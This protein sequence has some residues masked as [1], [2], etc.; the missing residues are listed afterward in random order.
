M[1]T[2]QTCTNDN[3]HIRYD[4]FRIHITAGCPLLAEV[5]RAVGL[6]NDFEHSWDYYDDVLIYQHVWDEG[7]KTEEGSEIGMARVLMEN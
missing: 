3:T 1:R 2:V 5:A 7:E 4:R 6:P